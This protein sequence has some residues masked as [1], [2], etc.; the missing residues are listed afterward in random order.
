MH[1]INNSQDNKLLS[2]AKNLHRT[3]PSYKIQRKQKKMKKK[4]PDEMWIQ[5]IPLSFSCLISICS[6]RQ[7]KKNELQDVT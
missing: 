3:D 2:I 5:T 6:L 4:K 7:V 1:Q